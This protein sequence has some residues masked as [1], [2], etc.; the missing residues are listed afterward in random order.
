[1]AS[2]S[3][4]TVSFALSTLKAQAPDTSAVATSLLIKGVDGI[5]C[6]QLSFGQPMTCTVTG[7]GFPL[8]STS[9]FSLT[10]TACTGF[11]S[12]SVSRDQT[13]VQYYRCTPTQFGT[14]TVTLN[15]TELG[16]LVIKPLVQKIIL[17]SAP[18]PLAAPALSATTD[19]GRLANDGITNNRTPVLS[20]TAPAF[21]AIDIYDGTTKVGS[22]VADANGKWQFAVTSA[23]GDGAHS[24]SVRTTQ[25]GVT[26]SSTAAVVTIDA[27][28][29]SAPTIA[30]ALR[31]ASGIVVVSGATEANAIITFVWPDGVTQAIASS[32][33]GVWQ[34]TST[35]AYPVDGTVSAA[36][37]DIAGNNS[38]RTMAKITT[39]VYS[40][41]KINDTGQ[42]TCLHLTTFQV[43]ACN[44][45]NQDGSF[46]RDQL[47]SAGSLPKVGF[48]V[49]G[50]DW[51]KLDEAGKALVN[52][53]LSWSCI[54]DNI[55][56]FIWES[57]K[58]D[59]SIQDKSQIFGPYWYRPMSD[60]IN[61]LNSINYCGKSDWRTPSRAEV[62]STVY[63]SGQSN[64][65]G[66]ARTYNN[67]DVSAFPDWV[68]G[69]GYWLETNFGGGPDSYA[70][71]NIFDPA[72]GWT[73]TAYPLFWD[74][75]AAG[76][77]LISSTIPSS[78]NR[79]LVT[80]NGSTVY[81]AAAN[82]TWSRCAVGQTV[83]ANTC[84]G[85][86]TFKS[87][88]TALLAV[89]SGW[90][91]PNVKE[92]LAISEGLP[93]LT[94]S[95]SM[96]TS[97]WFD[98]TLGKIIRMNNGSNPHFMSFPVVGSSSDSGIVILVKDGM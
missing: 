23:L 95:E 38:T 41:G 78:N 51:T 25:G 81:D 56:G 21:A 94:S 27:T 54:R 72:N 89:D 11:T 88:S 31:Q 34:A 18:A 79:F 82:I 77:R 14:Q 69:Y 30:Q 90:R 47:A 68:P 8:A 19:T 42:I 71:Q 29:P 67:Y 5:S 48:G 37:T 92:S 13:T 93:L 66:S 91:L 1:L 55:T 65:N 87:I 53:S 9:D 43:A 59:G 26:V 57:K 7:A 32:A 12:N 86:A 33:I 85:V 50:F 98:V 73:G 52:D 36:A 96:W 70:A 62:L 16:K 64:L 35:I 39:T 24:V 3:P 20:G 76:L 46:G 44:G 84:T 22:T 75:S 45:L 2:R 15:W 10:T 17:P 80:N 28:A 61:K 63:Y 74:S 4:A 83:S 49:A 97:T 58:S 60:L 6:D 40:G